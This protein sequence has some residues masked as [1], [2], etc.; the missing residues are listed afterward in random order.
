MGERRGETVMKREHSNSRGECYPF[1]L[2]TLIWKKR[3]LFGGQNVDHERYQRKGDMS[4]W[5]SRINGPLLVEVLGEATD[6]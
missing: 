3:D 1:S 4:A 2:S 5:T 6:A